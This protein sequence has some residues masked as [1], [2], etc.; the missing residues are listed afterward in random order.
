MGKKQGTKSECVRVQRGEARLE[1]ERVRQRHNIALWALGETSDA[2]CAF[3][4][5][6]R[7]SCSEEE[8]RAH[9]AKRRNVGMESERREIEEEREG[10]IRH[11]I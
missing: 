3:C 5:Q 4:M 9:E 10:C 11:K 1:A 8:T 2:T 7:L 6:P